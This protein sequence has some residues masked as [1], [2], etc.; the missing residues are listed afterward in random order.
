MEGPALEFKACYT[1]SDE[2][3]VTDYTAPSSWNLTKDQLRLH[4]DQVDIFQKI[5]SEP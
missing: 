1:C 5:T 4:N 2:A 3:C